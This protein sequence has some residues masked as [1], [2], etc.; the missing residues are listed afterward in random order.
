MADFTLD[1][2]L[3][4]DIDWFASVCGRMVHAASNGSLIPSRAIDRDLNY[5]IRKTIASLTDN[6]RQYDVITNDGY[7][8]ERLLQSQEELGVSDNDLQD[9]I[10]TYEE[11][12]VEMAR[13]GFYSFDRVIEHP[14]EEIDYRNIEYYSAERL[15][16]YGL[17]RYVLIAM[18]AKPCKSYIDNLPLMSVRHIENRKRLPDTYSHEEHLFNLNFIF[19]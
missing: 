15:Y 4:H 3:T 8:R 16:E 14:T 6:R 10:Q 7:V 18:P 11:S 17:T 19:E 2:Q 12:F 9:A 13:L 1:Y 5:S